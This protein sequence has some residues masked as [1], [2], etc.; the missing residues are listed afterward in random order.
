[1]VG[2]VRVTSEPA[3]AF[4]PTLGPGAKR[5]TVQCVTCGMATEEN[6]FLP[7]VG[8]EVVDDV[9]AMPVDA[10]VLGG[11][12]AACRE[13]FELHEQRQAMLAGGRR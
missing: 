7:T 9:L 3:A 4:D 12:A 13:C 8:G 2:K 11:S 6:W 1:M 10:M 5:C